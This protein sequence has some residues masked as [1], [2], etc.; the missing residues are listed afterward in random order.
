MK[1]RK[2]Q[3]RK[4]KQTNKQTKNFTQK[5]RQRVIKRCKRSNWK[6]GNQ[7]NK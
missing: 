6:F 5:Q 1:E 4:T 2:T 3:N 7:V